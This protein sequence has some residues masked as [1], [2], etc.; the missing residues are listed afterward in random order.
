[1][2]NLISVLLISLIPTSIF[3]IGGFGLQLGQGSFSV[4]ASSPDTNI[5]GVTLMNGAFDGSGVLGGYAYID[6]IPFVDIEFDFNIQGNTY[7]IA[8]SYTHL[9]LPTICSV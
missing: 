1:M 5:P 6:L 7:D 3:A 2:K 9:T 4:D 8:V